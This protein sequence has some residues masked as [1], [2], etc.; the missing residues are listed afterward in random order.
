MHRFD[1]R[2]F[3]RSPGLRLF[4]AALLLAGTSG[5][6]GEAEVGDSELVA[7][8]GRVLDLEARLEDTERAY[9]ESLERWEELFDGTTSGGEAIHTVMDERFAEITQAL[10][11]EVRAEVEGNLGQLR[12]ALRGL[13]EELEHEN[14]TLE[15][16]L[17]A[18]RTELLR[19]NRSLEHIDERVEKMS[20]APQASPEP[21]QRRTAGSSVAYARASSLIGSIHEFDRTRLHCRRCPQYLKI[22]SKKR[23]EIARFHDELAAEIQ[24][25][26][27]LLSG[28][29][30]TGP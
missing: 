30:R 25:L 15:S 23:D 1:H 8:K 28:H 11:S 27:D 24:A 18:M 12:V 5:C 16:E 17:G 19:A 20:E 22:K 3:R 9:R 26:Q 14:D 29:S 4:L 10:P 6:G 21:E 13:V 2:R 7:C